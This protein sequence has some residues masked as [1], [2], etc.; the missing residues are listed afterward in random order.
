MRKIKNRFKIA[1]VLAIFFL[2]HASYAMDREE[3]KEEMANSA[4]SKS[5]SREFFVSFESGD[6]SG[7]PRDISGIGSESDSED[8]LGRSTS[9]SVTPKKGAT[10][11]PPLKQRLFSGDVSAEESGEADGYSSSGKKLD[12]PLGQVKREPSSSEI[13]VSPT[14]Y[15]RKK[16]RDWEALRERNPRAYAEYSKAFKRLETR[17]YLP[18]LSF[19]GGGIRGMIGAKMLAIFEEKTGKQVRELFPFMAGTST[20]GLLAALFKLGI[21]GSEAVEMYRQYATS[22]FESQYRFNPSGV[23]G[24]RYDIDNL[25]EVIYRYV[26]DQRL[27]DVPG[28]LLITAYNISRNR[29]QVFKSW[30]ARQDPG[31]EMR[32]P[33]LVDLLAAT[34]AAPTYFDP[35]VIDGEAYVDGGIFANDPGACAYAEITKRYGKVNHMAVL[36]GTGKIDHGLREPYELIGR[37]ALSQ[38]SDIIDYAI[39]GNK[40]TARYILTQM[41]PSIGSFQQLYEIDPVVAGECASLDC[42]DPHVIKRLEHYA[43]D[44]VRE[45]AGK[46]WMRK[47]VRN[48]L[49]KNK[50]GKIAEPKEE[51]PDFLTSFGSGYLQS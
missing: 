2:S 8:D 16:V 43:D 30:E 40:D 1:S 44:Y 7:T 41:L 39:T 14:S 18:W 27:A 32:N 28:D 49:S 12:L 37:G 25:K 17:K 6:A 46:S 20:G 22:I 3:S 13:P 33:Y 10:S 4:L 36:V 21:P 26:G 48:L 42:T 9:E 47:L 24:P 50:E 35:V 51:F 34:A 38:V 19:S 15:L 23:R 31:N 11:S 29:T 45:E 5:S